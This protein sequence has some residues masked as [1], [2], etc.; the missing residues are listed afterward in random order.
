MVNEKTDKHGTWAYH[1]VDGLYQATSPEHYQNHLCHI[2]TTNSEIFT[3]TTQLSH[4]KIT[5]LTITHAVK[6]MAAIA[7]FNKAI[8]NMGSNDGADELKQ[9]MKLIEKQ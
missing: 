6:I 5:K 1:S 7:D 3:D 4:Q 9:L 8:R 2:K